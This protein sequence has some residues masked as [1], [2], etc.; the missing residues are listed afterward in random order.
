MYTRNT[1][2]AAATIV[3]PATNP[4][5]PKVSIPPS[6]PMNSNNSLSRVRFRSSIGRTI[7]SA[8]VDTPPQIAATSNAFP[9]C[10]LNTSQSTAGPQ[11]K[12]EPTTGTSEKNAIS[13]PQKIGSEIPTS[14]NDSPP[15]TP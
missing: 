4:S 10:P 14:A 9:Q 12:S 2:I 11:T 7:L 13:T 1:P 6:T 15:S 3:G 5:S 8:T